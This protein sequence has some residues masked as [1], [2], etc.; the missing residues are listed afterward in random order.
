MDE[1]QFVICVTSSKIELVCII[2]SL[3]LLF[4]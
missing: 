3:T 2:N 1:K 4:F